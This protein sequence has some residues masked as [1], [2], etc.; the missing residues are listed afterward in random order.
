MD[1]LA[2]M[3]AFQ[4]VAEASS[5]AGA[6]RKLGMSRSQVNRLVIQ[7]E[8]QLAVS[9]FHRST[10]RV[11]L[12]AL[13]Q[14]YLAR[15]GAILADLHDAE[16]M[17]QDAQGSPLGEIKIN[18]PMSFGTLYLGRVLADFLRLYPDI[19]IQL[20]L[21][22]AQIDPMAQGFDLTLRIAEASDTMSMI[23]HDIAPMPRILCAAPA[24]L[25]QR[26]KLAELAD[27]KQHTCLH[28]GS[29][30]AGNRWQLLGPSGENQVQVTGSYCSNN[31]EV[32][33]QAAVAGMGVVLLP[34]FIVGA[35]LRAGRLVRVLPEYQAR[36]LS[37]QLL[38]APNRHLSERIRV[39]V[40]YMQA[41]FGEQP[42][43]AFTAES[44]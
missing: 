35:D 31:G 6:A 38:Y 23:E 24:Y 2:A 26:G 16:C 43:W 21:S 1:K 12:T 25:Q 4:A 13:G 7:L 27:L 44:R 42:P 39:F 18:A 32:L 5:F 20:F 33:C 15:V 10:R 36:P 30:P 19:S 3:R 11:Q 8:D 9:L 14:A 40:K 17:L 34:L 22:D 28:Y 29:L 41:T 37:L